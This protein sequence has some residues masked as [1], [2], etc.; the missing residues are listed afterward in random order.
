LID[1]ILSCQKKGEVVMGRRATY[2]V[3]LNEG[4]GEELTALTR[5]GKESV[6]KVLFARALLLLDEGE[7]GVERWKVDSV[8]AAVGMS[9]RTLEHLKERLV[10]FGL[11]AAL[12]RKKPGTPSKRWVFDGEFAAQLTRLACSPAPEGRAR[13]TVRLLAEQLVELSIVPS[14]SVMTVQNTLKK[15]NWRLI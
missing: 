11:E 15:T 4:E 8:A 13:W 12:E 2:K 5:K 1:F 7:F 14:V 6:R 10:K 9:D 3:T